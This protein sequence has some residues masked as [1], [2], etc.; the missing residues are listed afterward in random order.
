MMGRS[1]QQCYIPS[2][3]KIGLPIPV[4]KIFKVFTIYEHGGHLGNV[5]SII[6]K[7]FIS[8]YLKAYIQNLFQNG[9]VVSKK[10]VF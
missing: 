10:S 4:K 7:I 3:V 1:P 2:F 6:S 5:T 8:M 9:P